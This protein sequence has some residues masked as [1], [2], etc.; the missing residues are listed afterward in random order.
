M[1]YCLVLLVLFACQQRPSVFSGEINAVEDLLVVERV[2][3][4]LFHGILRDLVPDQQLV[5]T[6]FY[7]GLWW[8]FHSRDVKP[9]ISVLDINDDGNADCALFVHR[10]HCAQLIF[11][12]SQPDGDYVAVESDFN[13]VLTGKNLQYGLQIEAPGRIDRIV[14]NE[15]RSLVLKT[16]AIVL[17]HLERAIRVFY[18]DRNGL[19]SFAME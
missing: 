4:S 19:L 14:N 12:V 10:N 15:D 1:K 7:D 13:V 2:H 17:L 16:N 3:D 9:N 11:I 6:S 8:S 18:W 5:D